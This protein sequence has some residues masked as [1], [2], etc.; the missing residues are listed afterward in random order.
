M[1]SFV[2]FVLGM[3][4]GRHRHQGVPPVKFFFV[5][6]RRIRDCFM[7]QGTRNS[8]SCDGEW[9][10]ANEDARLLHVS[11]RLEMVSRRNFGHNREV[12]E[13]KI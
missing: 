3:C 13:S 12:A 9:Y 5:A 6:H 8:F 4:K 2:F 11:G 10:G 7:L 1:Y